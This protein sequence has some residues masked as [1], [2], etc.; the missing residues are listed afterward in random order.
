MITSTITGLPMSTN[1]DSTSAAGTWEPMA[2]K[3]SWAPSSMKKNSSRKSRKP[4]SDAA[5]DSR[6]GVDATANPARKAPTSTEK[7]NQSLKAATD[8]AHAT[9][10]TIS[11][12]CD[13][14]TR[15]SNRGRTKRIMIAIAATSPAPC[16][17]TSAIWT[18]TEPSR[19]PPTVERTIMTST[20][21]M[22][23]TIR[24]PSA[25]RPWSSSSSRLS[26]S[27]LT[28][29]IVDENVNATATYNAAVVDKPSSSAMPNPM[30]DVNATCPSP[31]ISATLPVVRTR[32]RSSLSPTRNSN[33]AIPI[34]ANSSIGS[35]SLTQS[36][37][38]GPTMIPTAMNPTISG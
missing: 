30:I 24:N 17:T 26:D 13:E 37:T 33:T 16:A 7:P 35:V 21:T 25:M 8:I 19:S 10:D 18:G 4:V 1:T 15:W 38:D 20:T 3:S 23:C 6:Y 32:C 5:I 12:S 34:S 11:S 28:M 29:M 9:A 27:S 22:S 14:A 31:V 36:S 2:E